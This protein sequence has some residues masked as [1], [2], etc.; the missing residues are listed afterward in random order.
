VT[1]VRSVVRGT[2]VVGRTEMFP[3]VASGPSTLQSRIPRVLGVGSLYARRPGSK[4][5]GFKVVPVSGSRR[6]PL[7]AGG[8]TARTS[9]RPS[10]E[11]GQ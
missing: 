5:P 1:D 7:F 3:S 8:T 9:A 11:K 10:L 2:S 6:T 4:L